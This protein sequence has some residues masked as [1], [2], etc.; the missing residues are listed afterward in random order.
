MRQQLVDRMF[1]DCGDSIPELVP[2]SPENP[3]EKSD[4]ADIH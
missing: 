2:I 4:L 1:A 3:Q